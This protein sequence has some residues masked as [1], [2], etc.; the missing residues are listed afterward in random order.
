MMVF[1]LKNLNDTGEVL[2]YGTYHKYWLDHS[3]RITN[4]DFDD[5]SGK[6][7]DLK[8]INEN[9]IKYF[10]DIL[11][12]AIAK[13]ITICVVPSHISNPSEDSGIKLLAKK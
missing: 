9:A 12:K 11:D 2:V 5:L 4:P 3:N 7:L 6:I 1:F 13:D 10:F 8:D